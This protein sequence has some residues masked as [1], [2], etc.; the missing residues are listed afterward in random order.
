MAS[1]AFTELEVQECKKFLQSCTEVD[2]QP[3]SHFESF[4]FCM[5]DAEINGEVID[6]INRYL[7]HK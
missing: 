2:E 1:V 5:T 6:I 3:I 7:H 4:C